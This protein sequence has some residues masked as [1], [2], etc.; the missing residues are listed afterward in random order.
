MACT[1]KS[2]AATTMAALLLALPARA[3]DDKT[4]TI[5]FA[6]AA[7]GFMEAY[8]KPAQD[9]AMIR[10]DEINAAGGLNG[11]QIKVVTADT[12]SDPNAHTCTLFRFNTITDIFADTCVFGVKLCAV[13]RLILGW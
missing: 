9:A 5:G 2:V 11:K 4:I 1:L 7:S 3:E 8:D 10:I 6:T 13:P 12:K